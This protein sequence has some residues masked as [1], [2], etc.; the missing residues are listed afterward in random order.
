[1]NQPSYLPTLV[2]PT[3]HPLIFRHANHVSIPGH[4]LTQSQTL[5]SQLN[6]IPN[7]Q[8]HHSYSTYTNSSYFFSWSINWK[9][10]LHFYT[11]IIIPS[12][13]IDVL[14]RVSSS[15]LCAYYL[16]NKSCLHL[17]HTYDKQTSHSIFSYYIFQVICHYV[18]KR[19]EEMRS[20]LVPSMF[21][22]RYSTDSVHASKPY[23]NLIK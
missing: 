11:I 19:G 17:A 21:S 9:V 2:S 22:V 20:L 18:A 8:S 4:Y 13:L 5:T 16:C 12:T 23:K 7:F 3:H 6:Q 10:I 1:M 15:R 14:L